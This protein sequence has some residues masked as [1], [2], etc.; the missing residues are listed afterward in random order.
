MIGSVD[1]GVLLSDVGVYFLFRAGNTQTL[2]LEQREHLPQR[3][4]SV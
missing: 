1:R 2:Y 4:S 3:C